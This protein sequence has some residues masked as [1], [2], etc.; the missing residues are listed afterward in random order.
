MKNKVGIIHG[1]PW[2]NLVPK[3]VYRFI[4]KNEIDKRIIHISKEK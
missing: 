3:S 1:E 4:K 2:E